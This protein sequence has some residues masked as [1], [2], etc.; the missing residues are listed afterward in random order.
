MSTIKNQEIKVLVAPAEIFNA[1]IKT[2]AVT[3]ENYQAAHFVV[4]SGAG[5][6]G[7]VLAQVIG[8]DAEGEKEKVLGER[9]ITIGEERNEQLVIGADQLAHDGFDRVYL[10]VANAGKADLTG[11]VSV[12]LT[13]ERYSN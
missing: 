6:D 7:N 4:A 2:D 11:S 8:T 5:A 3:M 12:L 9:E 10:K 13:N 1:E